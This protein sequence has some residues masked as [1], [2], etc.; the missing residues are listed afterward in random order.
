MPEMTR[1]RKTQNLFEEV[2]FENEVDDGLQPIVSGQNQSLTIKQRKRSRKVVVTH[3]GTNGQSVEGNS[4]NVQCHKKLKSQASQEIGEVKNRKKRKRRPRNNKYEGMSKKVSDVKTVG[5]C[6]R[7]I[8]EKEVGHVDGKI[9]RRKKIQKVVKER[10]KMD[11]LHH[12]DESQEEIN[13]YQPEIMGLTAPVK[14]EPAGIIY[15]SSKKQRTS[16]K[17]RASWD[18]Q[19]KSARFRFINET[20]YKCRGDESFRKFKGDQSLFE[21]YHEGFSQQIEHWPENPVDIII[22]YL[23]KRPQTWTVGDFGCGEAKIAQSVKQK[24]YSFDIF[25]ANEKVTVCNISKVPLKPESLDVAVYCLSLMGINWIDYLREAYR[26]LKPGGILKIAEVASRFQQVGAFNEVLFKLGFQLKT[27]D[28]SNKMFYLF[29]FVKRNSCKD[30]P[31][32][33]ANILKPCEYKRR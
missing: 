16:K 3:M 30:V 25:P 8:E 22:R 1:T 24:V 17:S 33:S 6:E 28:L 5:I 12:K 9:E 21:V 7:K 11:G 26:V 2:P 32:S 10:K 20:L 4:V 15:A 18:Q 29:D 31:A 23:N 19:L 13:S 14:M 27:K